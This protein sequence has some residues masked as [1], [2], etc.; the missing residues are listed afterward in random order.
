MRLYL[1]QHG[2]AKTK[3]ED[4]SRPL[5][6]AGINNVRRIALYAAG[7][8]DVKPNQIIHSGATRAEQSAVILKEHLNPPGG[9]K[10]MEYLSP[11][12]DPEIWAERVS[13]YNN[14]LMLVGHLPNIKR[15]TSLLLCG[16]PDNAIVNFQNAGIVCLSREDSGNWAVCWILLPNMIG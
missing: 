9:I 2:E 6:D 1:M 4:P 10:A 14:D 12:D 7:H 15:L 8:L 16:N 13:D 5:T 11:M 3:E